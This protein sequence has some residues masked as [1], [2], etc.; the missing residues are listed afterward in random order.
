VEFEAPVFL[1]SR[2]ALEIAT[3]Q[4]GSG[5]WK[6]STFVAWNPGSGRRHFSGMVS[7]LQPQDGA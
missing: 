6:H 4:S 1:P 2:V 3:D 7:A 5:A